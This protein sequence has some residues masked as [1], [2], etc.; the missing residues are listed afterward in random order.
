MYLVLYQILYTT[1]SS[2]LRSNMYHNCQKPQSQ[3][4]RRGESYFSSTNI[5]YLNKGLSKYDLTEA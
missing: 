5:E 1:T 2:L 4:W 3:T